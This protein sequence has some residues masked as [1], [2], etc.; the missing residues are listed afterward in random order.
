[1]RSSVC[2]AGLA[3][4]VDLV[5]ISSASRVVSSYAATAQAALADGRAVDVIVKAPSESLGA[6]RLGV[7]SGVVLWSGAG[8][9]DLLASGEATLN[10]FEEARQRLAT[11][12]TLMSTAVGEAEDQAAGYFQEAFHTLFHATRPAVMA[13]RGLRAGRGLPGDLQRDFEHLVTTCH[14]RYVAARPGSRRERGP[15]TW[16]SPPGTSAPGTD[17][18]G[19]GRRAHRRR[20]TRHSRPHP[21]GS[22]RWGCGARR[23][24]GRVVAG[25]APASS[26][27]CVSR[28][29]LKRASRSPPPR[30]CCRHGDWRTVA[31]LGRPQPQ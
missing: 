7:A 27:P 5:L 10:D 16:S 2:A 28:Q 3:Q 9:A 4:D 24:N 21:G 26:L 30:R 20:R 14:L 15:C 8:A 17:R 31:H 12:A 25:G 19:G 22:G 1:M 6:L 18:R 13:L 29:D 11:A 23:L